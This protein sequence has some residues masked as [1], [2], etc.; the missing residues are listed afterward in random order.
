MDNSLIPYIVAAILAV[1]GVYFLM[2]KAKKDKKKVMNILGVV[3]LV[4]AVFFASWQYGLLESYGIIPL[5]KIAIPGTDLSL[6]AVPTTGIG[7]TRIITNAEDTTVTWAWVNKYTN[8]AGGGT[9]A[10]RVSSDGGRTYSPSKTVSDGGTDT[11]SPGDVVQTLFGNGTD[12]TY[13]GVVTQETIP[14]RGTYTIHAKA[15]ANGTLTIRVFNEE[16]NIIDTSGENETIGA[17]D[18]VNLKIELQGPNKAGFPYGGVLII[19]LNGTEYDEEEIDLTF[20]DLTLRKV[21]TPN[22]HTITATDNKVITYEVSAIEG[23]SVHTGNLYLKADDSI[24]PGNTGD[25]IIVFRPYDYFINEDNGGAFEGP[26]V[27][28]ED[29]VAT[30]DHI[31]STT[32]SVD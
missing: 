17:G 10:Y 28:D 15:V 23:T 27:E 16:G 19:E 5:G 11:L 26:A 20:N 1:A 8:V 9:H 24:N 12:T 18:T 6:T 31:T 4:G 13:F 22:V 2:S 21:S 14:N 29:N 7:G 25:P 32:I 30:F 3:L